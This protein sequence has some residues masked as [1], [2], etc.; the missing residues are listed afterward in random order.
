MTR[1]ERNKYNYSLIHKIIDGIEH[2]QCSKCKKWYPCDLDHFYKDKNNKSDGLKSE[3]KICSITRSTKSIDNRREE[4]LAYL[5]NYYQETHEQ[6]IEGFHKHRLDSLEEHKAYYA[7]YQKKNPE[8]FIKYGK[9]QRQNHLHIMS[10]QEWLNCKQYFGNKCAY[11]GMPLDQHWHWRKGQLILFD[12]CKDHADYN[13]L[14]DLSNCIP[15][16]KSCNS[17]KWQSSIEEWYIESN[18][19]YDIN[20]LNLIKSWLE[21]D[22]LKYIINIDTEPPVPRE[23]AEGKTRE[24]KLYNIKDP[25]KKGVRKKR[26]VFKDI[27]PIQL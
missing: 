15:A 17:H 2:K 27:Q 16:C 20:K 24:G 13:G 8:Y 5:K 7:D 6:Q 18:P 12:F 11:C 14:R 1:D 10:N 21:R 22:Y 19:V 25:S 26:V 9:E 3:C 4:Y 23:R